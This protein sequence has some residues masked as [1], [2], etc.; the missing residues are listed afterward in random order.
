MQS[1]RRSV[2][3]AG[4]GPFH[5]HPELLPAMLKHGVQPTSHTSPELVRG[6]IRDLYKYEIRAL[7]ERY[8]K[9]EF[10]KKQYYDLVDQLRREYGILAL[11][12][13]QLVR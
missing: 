12:P 4:D 1:W 13:Q 3:D 10:D 2:S 11:L 5:Y 6:Y 7:R 8:L 9:K